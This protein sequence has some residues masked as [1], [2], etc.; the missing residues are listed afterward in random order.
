MSDFFK[1]TPRLINYCLL[2]LLFAA[3]VAC[4]G[5]GDDPV[6]NENPEVYNL[7]APDSLIKG[8]PD[9]TLIYLS[10]RDPQGLDDIDSVFFTVDRPDGST[11][12]FTFYMFDDGLNGGDSLAED[13][14]YTQGIQSPSSG[15]QTGDYVFH[16]SARDNSDNMSNTINKSITAYDSADPVIRRITANQYDIQ[17]QHLFVSAYVLD[18]QGPLNIERVWVEITYLDQDSLYGEFD[19][20]DFSNNGDSTALDNIYSL[21]LEAQQD[22]VYAEGSYMIEF[23]IIDYDG[24]TALPVDTTI[25]ID[26]PVLF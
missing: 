8:L 4:S 23:N 17:R 25:V 2:V 24:N 10:L 14:I 11:N 12:G 5:C 22:S 16:F 21:D 19:L 7:V 26:S 15:S 20:N 1:K 9:T 6:T 13:G 18:V 3:I